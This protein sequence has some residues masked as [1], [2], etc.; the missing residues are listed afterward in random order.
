MPTKANAYAHGKWAAADAAW[1]DFMDGVQGWDERADVVDAAMRC[2]RRCHAAIW[3]ADHWDASKWVAPYTGEPLP[4]FMLS[5]REL[6]RQTGLSRARVR[7]FFAKAEAAGLLIR[8]REPSPLGE[9]NGARP[10]IYTM[11]C[12]VNR[13]AHDHH[14]T[15]ADDADDDATDD[16]AASAN[17]SPSIAAKWGL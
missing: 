13:A 4:A 16:D 14:G 11:A 15:T 2:M 10:A 3:P 6:A 8:L 1:C 5:E 17:D 12:Y 7:T 9:G